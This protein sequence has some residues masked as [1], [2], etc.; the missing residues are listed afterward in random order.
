MALPMDDQ[1]MPEH[2]G[3]SVGATFTPLPFSTAYCDALAEQI[4]DREAPGH[5]DIGIRNL[6]FSLILSMR[7]EN[8]LEIGSHI[9][10]ASL[11]IGEA[12]RLNNFGKLYTI[13]PQDHYFKRL[14]YYIE[15][16]NLTRQIQPIQGFSLAEDVKRQLERIQ[17]FELIFIDACHDYEPVLK[18]IL[19]SSTLLRR[20]GLIVLHDTSEFARSYDTTKKGGVRQAIFDACNRDPSLQPIFLEYPFWLNKCGAAILCKQQLCPSVQRSKFPKLWR[21]LLQRR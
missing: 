11:V 7:P 18:E 9:G 16:A 3:W 20:D 13:E 10:T 5:S 21:K 19:Y 15:R 14:L 1:H 8:I 12:L 2:R 4:A 6:L 17:P